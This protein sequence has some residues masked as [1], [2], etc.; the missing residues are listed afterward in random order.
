MDSVR[1][2]KAELLEK[3]RE[4]RKAH[5]ELFLKAQHGFRERAVE[6]LDEMLNLA[7]EGRD[8][9]QYLGLTAPQDHTVEYDR[10]IQMLEMSQDDIVEIDHSAFAQLVRN[11]WAWFQAAT[12]TNMMYSSGGKIGGSR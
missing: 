1:V 5:H 10:A 4:N 9:R 7:R 8:I 2:N 6:E 12:A 11:E 3:V